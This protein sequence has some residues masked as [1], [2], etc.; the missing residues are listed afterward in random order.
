MVAEAYRTSDIFALTC[1]VAPNGDRDGLPNVLMEAQ[2]QGLPVVATNVSAIPELI[3]D[4]ET[5]LLAEPGDTAAIAAHLELLIRD[6]GRRDAIGAAGS[7]RVRRSFS[8]SDCVGSVVEKF[9]LQA[10]PS[11]SR[12]A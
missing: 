8:F 9:G 4:G 3:L 11:V 5:G 12:V 10:R 1:V 2:S 6:A 7:A